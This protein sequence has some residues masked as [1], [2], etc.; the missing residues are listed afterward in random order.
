[1]YRVLVAEDEPKLRRVLKEFFERHGYEVF[2]APDG[3]V[4]IEMAESVIIDAAILD[5]MMPKFDGFEVC[6]ALR[7]VSDAPVIFLT[8]RTAEED[9]LRG[10][11]LDGDDYVTKP[12]SL[13]VLLARVEALIKRRSGSGK[14][15]VLEVPGIIINL[16]D[17]TVKVDGEEVKMQPRIYDLLIFFMKNRGRILTRE[18]LLDNVWGDDKAVYDL[19]VDAA[20][21][22][23][24][25]LLGARSGYVHTII[26]VGYRFEVE[27]DV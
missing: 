21:K 24:R 27:E 26:K 3:E 2:D 13:P 16:E 17:R 15:K 1:M 23:L 7:K 12:F 20:I 4:A 6:R 19:S 9:Q 10:F 8:A 25:R 11:E 14:A 22:K 5:V 18:Q